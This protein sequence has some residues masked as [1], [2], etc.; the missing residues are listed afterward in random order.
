MA[1]LRGTLVAVALAATTLAGTANASTLFP[2][3]IFHPVPN[4]RFPRNCTPHDIRIVRPSAIYIYHVTQACRL[5]LV[6]K[7]P[8]QQRATALLPDERSHPPPR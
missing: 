7:I 3:E 8:L 5:V 1:S 6:R 4:P 2:T